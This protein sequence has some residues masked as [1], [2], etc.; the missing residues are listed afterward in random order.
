MS[1]FDT[2]GGKPGKP[3]PL[4]EVPL[5]SASSRDEGGPSFFFCDVFLW[6]P[7]LSFGDDDYFVNGLWGSFWW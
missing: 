7:N 1:I 5:E 4:L 3:S 2:L 6:G